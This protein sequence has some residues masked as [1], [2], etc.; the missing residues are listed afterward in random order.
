MIDLRK[1]NEKLNNIYLVI[2]KGYYDNQY[3]LFNFDTEQLL[4]TSNN[5]DVLEF[6]MIIESY[7]EYDN[8]VINVTNTPMFF[9]KHYEKL[10]DIIPNIRVINNARKQ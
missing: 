6:D 3:N 9:Q 4:C 10:K 1:E 8:I 2:R 5:F 7:K